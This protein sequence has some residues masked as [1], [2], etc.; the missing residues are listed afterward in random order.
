MNCM[1]GV[2]QRRV[3]FFGKWQGQRYENTNGRLVKPTVE[4]PNGTNEAN[5]LTVAP[6]NRTVG[7]PEGFSLETYMATDESVGMDFGF[8]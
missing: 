2:L 7:S 4:Q 8:S 6:R 3:S 1:A 5:T